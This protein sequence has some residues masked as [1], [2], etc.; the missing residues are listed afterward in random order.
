MVYNAVVDKLRIILFDACSKFDEIV[1]RA[2]NALMIARHLDALDSTQHGS[3][4]TGYH[5]SDVLLFFKN[6]DWG[7]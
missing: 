2:Q 1:Q 3:K 4:A 6:I 7:N 5:A